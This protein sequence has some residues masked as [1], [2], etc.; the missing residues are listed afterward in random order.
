MNSEAKKVL[1]QLKQLSQAAP[2]AESNR[3]GVARARATLSSL[4]APP[5]PARLLDDKNLSP[6]S[7]FMVSQATKLALICAV[8]IAI[9]VAYT[10]SG[11]RRQLAF[12]EVAEKVQKD[13]IAFFQGRQACRP[14]PIMKCVCIDFQPDGRCDAKRELRRLFDPGH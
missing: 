7:K 12:A 9:L 5:T 3:T 4:A 2:N 11:G 13:A 8:L 1:R 14:I 10:L 6:R